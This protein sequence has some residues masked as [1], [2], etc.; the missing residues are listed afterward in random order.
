MNDCA[1]T[2]Q[3]RRG[4]PR[5]SPPP[6]QIKVKGKLLAVDAGYGM[7]SAGSGSSGYIPNDL[8]DGLSFKNADERIQGGKGV[9]RSSSQSKLIIDYEGL[10][11]SP[12]QR[13]ESG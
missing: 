6:S 3:Y 7:H 8:D 13:S 5:N 11:L 10:A 4:N 2:E 12:T 9:K 1:K